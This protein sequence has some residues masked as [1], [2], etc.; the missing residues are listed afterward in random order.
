MFTIRVSRRRTLTPD[1]HREQAARSLYA[2]VRPADGLPFD[3]LT[4][5]QQGRLRG[6]IRFAERCFDAQ[7]VRAAHEA[8]SKQLAN[9]E[10]ES[11]DCIPPAMRASYRQ[12]GLSVCLVFERVL[13]DGSPETDAKILELARQDLHVIGRLRRGGLGS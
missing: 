4:P 7:A 5:G 2:L 3:E 11:L 10:D 9:L 1:D 6:L 12:R 13:T 8:V